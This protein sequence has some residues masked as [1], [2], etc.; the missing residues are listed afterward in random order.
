NTKG[1]QHIHNLETSWVQ[2]QLDSVYNDELPHAIKTGMIATH[3]TMALIQQYLRQHSDIPYVIDPVMLA[4]SGDSLID[5]ETKKH[6]QNTLLPL[7]DV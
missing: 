4:K 6:L 5:D 1:V 3:E 2:E 7:A